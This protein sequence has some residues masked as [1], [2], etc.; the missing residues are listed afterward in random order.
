MSLAHHQWPYQPMAIPQSN[1]KFVSSQIK[2]KTVKKI[3]TMFVV[4]VIINVWVFIFCMFVHV[5][6]VSVFVLVWLARKNSLLNT[7]TA[8]T[9]LCSHICGK[10]YIM[11]E[12]KTCRNTPVLINRLTWSIHLTSSRSWSVSTL[13]RVTIDKGTCE[14]WSLGRQ[15]VWQ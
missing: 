10:V 8:C 7:G 12:P 9:A 13:V 1:S 15:V 2:H 3:S 5:C 11:V 14:L 6:V 4:D